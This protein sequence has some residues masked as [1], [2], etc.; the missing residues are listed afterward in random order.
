M[1]R[2]GRPAVFISYS[3]LLEP[4]GQSQVLPYVRG[5]AKAGHRMI[6]ISFE[7]ATAEKERPAALRSALEREGIR[8]FALRYH[9]RLAVLST[10][11][12]VACGLLLVLWLGLRGL[13]LIH[14]RSHVPALIA[15]V[16]GAL[17]GVPF[18][19]DHRGLMAEEFA[20]ARIWPRDGALFRCTNWFE[21]VFLRRAGGVIVLTERLRNEIEPRGPIAVIPCA[22][23]LAHYRLTASAPRPYDL[24]YAGSW[25]GLYLAEETLRF[26][27]ALKAL[28]P[29]ARFLVLTA[30]GTMPPQLSDGVEVCSVL[31]E[32]V[33]G[34][35]GRARAGISLRRPGR[36]QVA[37]SPV[38]VSEYWACGLPVVTSPN[39]GDLDRLIEERG[40]GVVLSGFV[41]EELKAGARRLLEL[42]EEGEAVVGRCRA[43]AEERF[44]VA[45]AVRAY[46][47]LYED[48]ALSEA[49]EG[50]PRNGPPSHTSSSS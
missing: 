44:D 25:G 21:Q 47:R 20:D 33:P 42:V 49:P 29:Q 26:F 22:V 39:V 43:L 24:V 19:F 17:L 2:E 48:V 28:R 36:A 27:A 32:E 10:L 5:L 40:V 1:R 13:K 12:D 50:A 3:G 16:A 14:A 23:D 7:K 15:L 6:V 8:W 31:P 11:F 4:L 45:A 46:H 41:P 30:S 35:L 18:L 37:S 9:R 34:L 38:K